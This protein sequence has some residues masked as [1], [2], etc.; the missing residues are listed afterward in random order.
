MRLTYEGLRDLPLVPRHLV[1]PIESGATSVRQISTTGTMDHLRSESG[2]GAHRAAERWPYRRPSFRC[3]GCSRKSVDEKRRAVVLGGL[4]LPSFRYR[5][6]GS[7]KSG[8]MARLLFGRSRSRGGPR[9]AGVRRRLD[10]L[11]H[12]HVRSALRPGGP[13]PGSVGLVGGRAHS[14]HPA[15][16]VGPGDGAGSGGRRLG[17]GRD[18]PAARAE[19]LAVAGARLP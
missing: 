11:G 3:K 16:G 8:R 6:E 15:V 5:D 7:A 18:Y 12:D 10:Q 4:T 13:R 17:G 14:D 19:E 9:R 2:P 1:A